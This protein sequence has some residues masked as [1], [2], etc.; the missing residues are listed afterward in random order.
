MLILFNNTVEFKGTL[1][2]LFSLG[3]KGGIYKTIVLF[4]GS[5]G[6]SLHIIVGEKKKKSYTDLLHSPQIKPLSERDC[7]SSYPFKDPL[8]DEPTLLIG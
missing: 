6:L 8:P 7:F 1:F 2:S 4:W 5:T 3:I